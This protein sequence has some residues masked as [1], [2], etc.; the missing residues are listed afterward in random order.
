[1]LGYIKTSNN[2]CQLKNNNQIICQENQINNGL[3][4]C[5]C[6]QGYF[7]VSGQCVKDKPCPLNSLKT[8]DGN[9]TCLPNFFNISG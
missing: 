6:Q 1:M 3:N 9:C 2:S 4:I 5:I 7:N 8:Q